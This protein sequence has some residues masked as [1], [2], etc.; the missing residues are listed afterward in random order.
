MVYLCTSKEESA[1]NK[2]VFSSFFW[3]KNG[4]F[5]SEINFFTL[6]RKIFLGVCGF[7]L[8]NVGGFFGDLGGRKLKDIYFFGCIF[9]LLGRERRLEDA[10]GMGE[11]ALFLPSPA[12]SKQE[13]RNFAGWAQTDRFFF[14]IWGRRA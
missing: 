8:R 11:D 1:L 2:R 4:V 9:L 6:L 5:T 12:V 3:Q 14:P 10:R 13:I 7:F